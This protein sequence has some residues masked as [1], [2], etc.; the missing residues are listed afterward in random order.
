MIINIIFYCI[1]YFIVYQMQRL[2][3]EDSGDL[4]LPSRAKYAFE[5]ERKKETMKEIELYVLFSKINKSYNKS[6]TI[7]SKI[8]EESDKLKIKI[9]KELGDNIFTYN[10]DG[11]LEETIYDILNNSIDEL[12][13]NYLSLIEERNKELEIIIKK[14]DEWIEKYDTM[15]I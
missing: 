8:N 9:K 12:N 7:E 1:C 14:K 10:L 4:K 2:V 13:K 11:S 3:R 15:K 6:N 5:L